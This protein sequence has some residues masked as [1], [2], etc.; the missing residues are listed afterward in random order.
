M[1]GQ[2]PIGIILS[3]LAKR[4]G[5]TVVTSDLYPQ[6]LTISTSYG[7]GNSIDAS[8]TD[9]VKAVRERTE[10]RGADAAILAVGGN[11]LIPTAIDAVRPGGRVLLFAQTVH[12]EATFDPGAVCVDEK[13]LLGSYSASVELQEDSVRFV[14]DR[15]MDLERLITHR[16]SLSRSVEALNLAAHPQPD[17]MKIVIQPGSSWEGSR[18]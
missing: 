18:A 6:R 5:S 17:S 3:A 14:M 12:G 4:A 2:G 15:E 13:T 16:F 11:S 10:G 9:V 7:L 1:I 8:R